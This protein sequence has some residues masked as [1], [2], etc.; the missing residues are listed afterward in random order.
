MKKTL[1]AAIACA[2]ALTAVS[3]PTASAGTVCE[4]AGATLQKSGVY[5]SFETVMVHTGDEIPF[6][7]GTACRTTP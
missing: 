2:I 7:V 4:R 3:A 6:V 1:T 5:E